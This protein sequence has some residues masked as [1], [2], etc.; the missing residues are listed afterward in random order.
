MTFFNAFAGVMTVLLVGMLGYLMARRRLVPPETAAMLPK[1]LT[2]IVLPP[3][4]LRTVTA[5]FSHDQLIHLLYGSL[6]PLASM[7]I[8]FFAAV[9]LSMVMKVRDGRKGV[10]RAALATS[11]T[12]NI[13]LPINI[14][15]F[16]EAA[17]PYV[18]L[19]VFANSIFFWTF[20]NYAIAGDGPGQRPKLFSLDTLKKI[21]SPPLIGFLC[22]IA[23]VLL[24]VSLPSF[25]DKTFKYVG[26]MTV[27]IALIYVGILMNDIKLEDCRLEK[28]IVCVLAGRFILSPLCIVLLAA[29]FDIPPLMRNVFIIQSSLPVMMNVAVIAGLYKSDLHF[30]TVAISITTLISIAT[31]PIFM[32]LISNFM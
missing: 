23:L 13:G 4:L 30:A 18:L 8:V 17:L 19:Y 20:G 26:D 24:D 12:V 15:L 14:A 6:L 21:F 7:L 3:Y 5:S 9:P 1:F 16:G 22:G 11:N 31:I 29:L 2:S 32:M 10:F 27:A 28:D 25:V